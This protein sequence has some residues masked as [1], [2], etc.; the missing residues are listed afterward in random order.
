MKSEGF[1]AKVGCVPGWRY[2]RVMEIRVFGP[3]FKL[4]P[5]GILEMERDGGVAGKGVVF[6]C[7]G[8]SV[9]GWSRV[10]MV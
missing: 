10:V 5:M 8:A 6:G 1:A 7:F 9:S 3:V 4:L 2:F